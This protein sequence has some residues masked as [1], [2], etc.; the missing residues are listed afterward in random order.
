[1][2]TLSS[3][4]I[5]KAL[6][7]FLPAKQVVTES[8]RKEYLSDSFVH[9]VG[10]AQAL[11]FAQSTKEVSRILAWANENQIAVTPRGAG[12]NLVGSTIPYGGIVLDVSRINFI[13]VPDL[14]NFT[15]TVG[16][17]AKL[18]DVQE[19]VA[20]FGMLYAPDPGEKTAS[21][22]G[23]IATN[24]GGMRAVKYGVTRDSVRALEVVL[25]DGQVLQL[26]GKT[27]K[28][29][30]GLALK[31][32]FIGSEG[33]LGI[34]T[35]AVLRLVPAPEAETSV[36][37]GF[38]DLDEGIGAVLAILASGLEPAAVE[39]MDRKSIALGEDFKGFKYPFPE[40]GSYI[41]ISLDGSQQAVSYG[42]EQLRQDA[43]N[44]GA[45]GVEVLSNPA[46]RA[47]VWELR[48]DLVKAVEAIS[49]QE[50][51][52]IVVPL[53]ALAEYVSSIGELSE[54]TGM[55]MVAFGH[56]GDGNV[57]LCVLRDGRSDE[58]WAT[59]LQATLDQ[60]YA[61]AYEF[62]GL[63]SGE[64]GIGLAKRRF[65]LASTPPENLAAMRAIKAAL[66]PR[67]ILNPGKS[68]QA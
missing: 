57:H 21:I 61:S 56:A 11:V 25:A 17:G 10:E 31:H 55:R 52:D 66:D 42:V 39:F 28:D 32:L 40:A 45:L 2:A 3:A 65:F 49:E 6:T 58:A 5:A 9:T 44:L 67:G 15:I 35:R 30:S 63:T 41:L 29:A 48:G 62:G 53:G 60:L 47:R 16:P 46:D 34:V 8:I 24:A 23:T 27:A 68:Y 38:P 59:E 33:T 14:E 7:Q 43:E 12:T 51:I 37:L 50:P 1:M 54:R 19:Y 26:G 22:G 20:Q 13:D 4:E 36:L 64:H 18:A